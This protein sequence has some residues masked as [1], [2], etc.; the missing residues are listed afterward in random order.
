[1]VIM[2]RYADTTGAEQSMNG[3]AYR[4]SEKEKLR[5]WLEMISGMSFTQQLRAMESIY[6]SLLRLRADVRMI[7]LVMAARDAQDSPTICLLADQ[8]LDQPYFK[9]G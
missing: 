4:D 5:L 7:R 8:L 9:N 2:N 1:M 3:C 6:L